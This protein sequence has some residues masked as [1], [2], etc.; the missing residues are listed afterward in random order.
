M[1]FGNLEVRAW[2]LEF[3]AFKKIA[4][5]R[6]PPKNPIASRILQQK[7]CAQVRQILSA[8]YKT[9]ANLHISIRRGASTACSVAQVWSVEEVT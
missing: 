4:A 8:T 2:N 7:C 5:T 6:E 1:S 9:I 3:E